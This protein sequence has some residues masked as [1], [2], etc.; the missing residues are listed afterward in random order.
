[1]IA[2]TANANTFFIDSPVPFCCG[3][4]RKGIGIPS[5]AIPNLGCSHPPRT[6]GGGTFNDFPCCISRQGSASNGAGPFYQT[7][8]AS[9]V[10][11]P[12]PLNK[13]PLLPHGCE[14]PAH[15]RNLCVAS[16]PEL[17]SHGN[18]TRLPTPP[19]GPAMKGRRRKRLPEAAADSLIPPPLRIPC[20]EIVLT[21]E[22]ASQHLPSR[23]LSMPESRP[24]VCGPHAPD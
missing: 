3:T 20:T 8:A 11:L 24:A 15:Q 17:H 10:T 14:K 12:V 16:S 5:S 4:S 13:T 1:M 22:G 7:L 9:F 19:L 18:A 21:P 2:T 6:V 23:G